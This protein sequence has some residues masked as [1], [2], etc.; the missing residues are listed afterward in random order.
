MLE[1]FIVIALCRALAK[2]ASERGRS[3]GW[4]ALGAAFWIGGELSG[5]VLGALLD[6]EMLGMIGIGL[7]L[8]VLGAI[9]SW[10]IVSNLPEDPEAIALNAGY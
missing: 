8:A 10:V 5:I 6:L 3:K 4:A 1:L 7:S 2:K 9:V